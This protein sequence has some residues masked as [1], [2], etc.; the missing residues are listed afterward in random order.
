MR[1]EIEGGGMLPEEGLCILVSAY[2]H[3]AAQVLDNHECNVSDCAFTIAHRDVLKA[4]GRH[5]LY[6]DGRT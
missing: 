3:M 6:Y 2:R 1:I 4:V 5:P